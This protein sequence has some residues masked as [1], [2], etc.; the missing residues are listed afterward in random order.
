MN[1]YDKIVTEIS[2]QV[3]ASKIPAEYLLYI[4]ITDK[5]GKEIK[6]EKGILPYLSKSTD[7]KANHVAYIVDTNVIGEQADNLLEDYLGGIPE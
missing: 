4:K 6:V 2:N 7:W 3:D 1:V 5:D